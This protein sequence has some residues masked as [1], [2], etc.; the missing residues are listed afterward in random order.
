MTG[1]HKRKLA[2]KEAARSRAK[3]RENLER[4]EARREVRLHL[5]VVLLSVL[6]PCIQQRRMLREQAIENAA[7]VEKAYG[8][9]VGRW[10]FHL[11]FNQQSRTM[12]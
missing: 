9:T 5:Y 12:T 3:E 2:K 6:I 10:S 7:Q 11:N 4:L 1:F 8:A